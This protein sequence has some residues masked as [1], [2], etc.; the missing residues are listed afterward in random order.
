MAFSVPTFDEPMQQ[1]QPAQLPGP[2]V[3]TTA[4][5]DAFGD[6]PSQA[7]LNDAAMGLAKTG[8]DIALEQKDRA[9]QLAHIQA[10]T[11]LS[12]AQTQIQV[13]VSK[14]KGANAVGAGD[15][16][17]SK[18]QEAIDNIQGGLTGRIQQQA[19]SVTAG[20]RMADLN[21]S[22]QL[23]MASE[24]Q[25]FQDQTYQSGMDQAHTSAVVN[26][27]DD[28]QV[29]Q[30]LGIQHQLVDGWA[31]VKGIP[32]KN[33]DGSDNPIY[34]DKLQTATS[35]TKL[36][37]IHARL[38]A[39][40]DEGAQK[41]F[42][43]NKKSMTGADLTNALN[44][45]DA[46]KV[47]SESSDLF[48]DVLADKQFKYS[49]GSL[50]GEA[51]RKYVMDNTDGMSDQR[52]LK[53]LSQVKAQGAEYNRDRYH[54][55]AANERSFGD[56]VIQARQNGAS[57]QDALKLAPKWGYDAYD[58]AQKQAFIQKTYEP[59]T[60]T[61]V[62]AHEQLREGINNGAVEL[63]DIDRARDQGSI[64]NDD[65][66]SL[67]QQ[68]LKVAADGTDPNIKR[69]DGLIKDAAVKSFGSDKDALAQFQYVVGQKAQGKSA[70]EK[71][72]IAQ[73]EL[74]KVPDPTNGFWGN[75]FNH[76]T[77]QYKADAAALEGQ[78]T[79]T[80][81]MYQDIG[82]KQA[83]AMSAGITGAQFARDKNPAA[84]VQ[85][86]ANTL[87][88]KYED[89]KVGQPANNAIQSLISKGKLVTPQS[90]QKVL[91]RYPD[92]NWR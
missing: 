41:F 11:A 8:V 26:A 4:P 69:V 58:I 54:Q 31:K 7:K 50:N 79:A 81:V 51:I 59:P 33:P 57:L 40:Q 14:M 71:W 88:M 23:H 86:F 44:A 18:M 32:Q 15:Y 52:K 74:K 42:D 35:S 56:Q 36:G 83:Q 10:D 68:K 76:K 73:D 60:E 67:R 21:K 20:Q 91:Q 89:L 19:F 2:R 47:I 37:V 53:V 65:W 30:Q 84:N 64:N 3:S 39:G 12:Q 13:D 22:T 6:G 48:Q 92:G 80:G 49:D 27:G 9:N 75:L 24:F 25:N 55:M 29:Q 1:V 85:A 28:F 90:V 45:L 34:M 63:S 61:K 72:A 77:T 62:I 16:A 17:N 46:S 43:D 5:A 87:G 82:F 38:E 78:S 66:A 70:D